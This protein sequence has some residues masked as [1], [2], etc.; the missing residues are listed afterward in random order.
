MDCLLKRQQGCKYRRHARQIEIILGFT[1]IDNA[2]VWKCAVSCMKEAA[3]VA[4]RHVNH[5]EGSVSKV[6]Y[7]QELLR[8]VCKEEESEHPAAI[9]L[10][11]VPT[12]SMRLH[13]GEFEAT[14]T[15]HSST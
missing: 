1:K 4:G 14:V 3:A 8:G 12:F 11:T 10:L 2:V 15:P 5:E 9:E 7:K 6:C 13:C